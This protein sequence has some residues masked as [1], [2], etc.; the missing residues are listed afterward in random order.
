MTTINYGAILVAAGWYNAGKCCGGM[1]NF[2]NIDKPKRKIKVS[3]AGNY[4]YSYNEEHCV[5]ADPL[6]NL[7]QYLTTI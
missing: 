6:N 3:P 4:F 1:F 5:K 2:K 7:S